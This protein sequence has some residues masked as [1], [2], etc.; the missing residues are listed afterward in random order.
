MHNAANARNPLPA[1][2]V[3]RPCPA[4]TP[5]SPAEP[6]ETVTRHNFAAALPVIRAAIR[7]ATFVAIDAEFTGLSPEGNGGEELLDDYEERYR[8][9][10]NAA[11]SFVIGQASSLTYLAEQGFDFNK[12]IRD[13][14]G[15]LPLS[16][17]DAKAA[18]LAEQADNQARSSELKGEEEEVLAE[19]TR[20]VVRE[21]LMG[22][23]AELQPLVPYRGRVYIMRSDLPYYDV[24]GTD[25]VASRPAVVHVAG[26]TPATRYSYLQQRFDAAGLGPV[27]V[28]MLPAAS[29]SGSGG[30]FVQL[31]RPELVSRALAAA[32]KRA[33]DI[34]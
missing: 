10:A 31:S 32:R 2:H 7:D 29:G 6:P 23:E 3:L 18:G 8:R 27:Q 30:A 9:I 14:V 17:R 13:G 26:F 24:Y 33:R 21:W 20:R 5:A 25:P 28:C 4:F 16:Y 19:E 11:S 34:T 22:G 1:C 15:Y 12:M